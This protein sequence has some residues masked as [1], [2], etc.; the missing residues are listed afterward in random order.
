M[1]DARRRQQE[2]DEHEAIVTEKATKWIFLAT[3]TM[4]VLAVMTPVITLCL[5][6]SVGAGL[7]GWF[8]LPGH[9][10]ARKEARWLKQVEDVIAAHT[11]K[12]VAKDRMLWI[13]VNPI[14]GD[15]LSKFIL[16]EVVEPLLDRASISY[17]VIEMT[18][19][20]HA[21][22]VVSRLDPGELDGLVLIS[23]D[24]MVHQAM[25]GLADQCEGHADGPEFIAA[26]RKVCRKIPLGLVP[27]GSSNG[28]AASFGLF[29]P[30]AA[31]L[32]IIANA[33]QPLDVQEITITPQTGKP[34][35][36]VLSACVTDVNR[37][38][39]DGLPCLGHSP[40]FSALRA[41][42][43]FLVFLRFSGV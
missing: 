41:P 4:P 20:T 1:A 12:P 10:L 33:P 43:L 17:R 3:I 16:K 14:G 42:R 36:V 38:L 19:A 23:G 35:K 30:V 2:E 5:V 24:G 29:D 39:R 34:I 26:L 6:A 13:L 15:G 28:L 22:E 27:A 7:L 8:W 37:S 18:H 32:A 11:I 40:G 21:R 31:T 25:Q 9:L